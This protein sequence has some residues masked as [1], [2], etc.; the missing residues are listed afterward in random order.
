VKLVAL[1]GSPRIK[2]N[3]EILLDRAIESAE[4]KGV[5]TT[6]IALNTLK[7]RP[8]QECGGCNETGTCVISDDMAFIYES[9]DKADIVLVASPIFFANVAAQTKIMIDRMQCRW[10]KKFL[11]KQKTKGAEKKGAF[12]CCGALNKD[13]YFK[14]ASAVLSVFFLVQD[15]EYREKIFVPSVEEKGDVLKKEEVLESVSAMM[16]RLIKGN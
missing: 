14:C 7:I 13:T 8:C 5:D 2:G 4:D 1:L 16:D 9:I 15:I 10:A 6:K 3:S 11:L 12:I